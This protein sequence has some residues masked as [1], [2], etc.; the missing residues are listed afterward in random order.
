VNSQST[1]S[2]NE[3]WTQI[4]A[5]V[6]LIIWSKLAKWDTQKLEFVPTN[7]D[8]FEKTANG[9]RQ[10][11]NEF[12]R[13]ICWVA[14]GVGSEYLVKGICILNNQIQTEHRNVI[15]FPNEHE[16]VQDWAQKVCQT[17]I[18]PSVLETANSFGTFGT[19]VEPVK[20]ILANN[21]LTERDLTVAAIKLLY[22]TFRNRDAHQYTQNV[23]AFHFHTVPLVFVPAFNILLATAKQQDLKAFSA[24]VQDVF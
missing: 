24:C 6:S 21:S 11:H 22:K 8:E 5:G 7:K 9:W 23:R 10:V 2:I 19:L 20:Q 3:G 12:G 15:R 14:F 17:P 18:N 13:L 16:S 1:P 4:R